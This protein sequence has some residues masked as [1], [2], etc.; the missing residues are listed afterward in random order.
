MRV[1]CS[2][3]DMAIYGECNLD[4]TK[5]ADSPEMQDK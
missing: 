2:H 4:R 3:R 5:K 1:N